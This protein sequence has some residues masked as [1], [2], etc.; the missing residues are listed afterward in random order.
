[1]S[2]GVRQLTREALEPGSVRDNRNDNIQPNEVK[3]LL[4]VCRYLILFFDKK[5][6]PSLGALAE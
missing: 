1:M 5:D 6:M 4:S 3:M 2:Q